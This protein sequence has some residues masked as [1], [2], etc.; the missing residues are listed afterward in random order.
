M[1]SLFTRFIQECA[2][3]KDWEEPIPKS[4]NLGHIELSR[5]SKCFRCTST[6]DWNMD[7]AN[8]D[9]ADDPTR[10]QQYREATTESLLKV[11]QTLYWHGLELEICNMI[12]AYFE[13]SKIHPE[14]IK[15]E[16]LSDETAYLDAKN[17]RSIFNLWCMTS[18]ELRSINCL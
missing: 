13:M 6:S 17:Y 10:V 12:L 7:N 5:P 14:E 9:C 2:L 8:G 16:D 11:L 18:K 4:Q 15:H 1:A 3:R